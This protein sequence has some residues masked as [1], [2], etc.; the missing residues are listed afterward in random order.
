MSSD[1][2]DETDKPT[3][4]D[5]LDAYA[6]IR[7]PFKDIPEGERLHPN[8]YLCA[9]L[10]VASLL[11]K[12]ERFDMCPEHDILYLASERK[13]KPLTAEDILYLSRCG[14]HYNTE[15]G[16]LAMFM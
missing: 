4:K 3:L 6:C 15:N 5:R 11:I 7:T 14:V 8:R 12:P 16:C 2:S 9:L 1:F 13:L 10:K